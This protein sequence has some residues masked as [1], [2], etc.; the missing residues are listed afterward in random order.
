MNSNKTSNNLSSV[1]SLAH[2]HTR[3]LTNF[4]R[5]KLTAYLA[6]PGRCEFKRDAIPHVVII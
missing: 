2:I 3:D 6:H 1:R 5:D 4:I